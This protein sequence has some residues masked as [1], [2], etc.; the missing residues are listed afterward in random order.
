MKYI[1]VVGKVMMAY[2]IESVF[3]SKSHQSFIANGIHMVIPSYSLIIWR[4]MKK[5]IAFWIVCYIGIHFAHD[6]GAENTD[7]HQYDDAYS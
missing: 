5:N 4:S 6:I 1:F 7:T 2:N 3:A